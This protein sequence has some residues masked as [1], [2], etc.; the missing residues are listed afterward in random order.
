MNHAGTEYSGQSTLTTQ[1]HSTPGSLLGPPQEQST[2]G[3]LL[4][5]H[6][7]R[8]R[9]LRAVYLGLALKGGGILFLWTSV[10]HSHSHG[11]TFIGDLNSVMN[12]PLSAIQFG[13][14]ASC[15]ILCGSF[16]LIIYHLWSPISLSIPP[17]IH[18]TAWCVCLCSL[19]AE[20]VLDL[21]ALSISKSLLKT[22]SWAGSVCYLM[23][24]AHAQ[25]APDQ[26]LLGNRLSL[27]VHSMAL[28]VWP[29]AMPQS[30]VKLKGSTR[31]QSALSLQSI[32]R[33]RGVLD[34]GRRET[35]TLMGH[36][37]IRCSPL[38][39]LLR[40]V[41]HYL[42][43]ANTAEGAQEMG[44][45]EV[46]DH[47]LL[48]YSF[49]VTRSRHNRRWQHPANIVPVPGA[50]CFNGVISPSQANIILLFSLWAAMAL[51]PFKVIQRAF[52]RIHVCYPTPG[53]VLRFSLPMK[54]RV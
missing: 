8:V 24:E 46:I 22:A 20:Y 49:L 13:I 4:E 36:C 12:S 34:L 27:L 6:R 19:C 45:P 43:A 9:V 29:N 3:S 44:H 41:N 40:A 21:Q 25:P 18:G 38:S 37:S 39:Y 30:P 15:I 17:F 7:N 14:T 10:L 51:F 16:S 28:V 32:S 54:A 31:H 5:T 2:P 50:A 26:W 53:C 23:S 35:H 42:T 47:R 52:L 1:E 48:Q 11:L 33:N